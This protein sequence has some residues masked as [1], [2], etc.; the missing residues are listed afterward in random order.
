[1]DRDDRRSDEQSP[2]LDKDDERTMVFVMIMEFEPEDPK[3]E[4]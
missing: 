1:M 4:T 2:A 3:G